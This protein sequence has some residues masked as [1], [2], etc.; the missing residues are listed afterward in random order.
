MNPSSMPLSAIHPSLKEWGVIVQVIE[1]THIK[2]NSTLQQHY[3]TFVLA[4]TEGTTIQMHVPHHILDQRTELLVPFKKYYISG[5]FVSPPNPHTTITEYPFHFVATED[6]LI[7][8][9]PE[10]GQPSLPLH[11]QLHS[12][13]AFAVIADTDELI[14]VMGIVL[15]ALPVK[16]IT[17]EGTTSIARDYVIADQDMRPFILTLKNDFE[18]NNG[19]AIAAAENHFPV[20][21]AIRM[22]VTTQN[23]LSLST[24][25]STTILIAPIVQQATDLHRWY[26]Y[27]ATQLAQMVH[28]HSYANP[29][30]LLAPPHHNQIHDIAALLHFKPKT[31]WIKGVVEL[32]SKPQKLTYIACPN[33]YQ[34][35]SCIDEQKIICKYCQ[36]NIDLQPRACISIWITDS[37]GTLYLTAMASEAEKLAQFSTAELYYLQSENINMAQHLQ[38]ILHGKIII[39]YVKPSTPKFRMMRLSTYEIIT[40][41][42]MDEVH[43]IDNLNINNLSINN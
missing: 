3:R 41:Y 17:S 25:D 37:T 23:Y 42:T 8:E 6:T 14:N 2:Y 32:D 20:I 21:I 40:S 4:D 43:D 12:F 10:T 30:I 38:T 5:A 18:E 31:A 11:F 24:Q 15:H 28:D 35:G 26:H 19:P 1:A 29:R 36:A 34:P 9:I 33:C 27:N 39:C 7:Q 16:T 13:S 22:K